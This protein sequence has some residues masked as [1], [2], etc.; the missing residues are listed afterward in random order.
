MG[1]KLET[2]IFDV[3]GS[4]TLI[5]DFLDCC[6]QRSQPRLVHNTGV[7]RWANCLFHWKLELMIFVGSCN[8]RIFRKDLNQFKA[9]QTMAV[10][11][12][13]VLI[14]EPSEIGIVA[15]EASMKETPHV[16]EKYESFQSGD[17]FH[18]ESD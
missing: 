10:R 11:T 2:L 12:F 5:I 14:W 7:V 6:Q 3:L 1:S 18:D 4:P 9:K 8:S 15:L 13:H 17:R 16:C